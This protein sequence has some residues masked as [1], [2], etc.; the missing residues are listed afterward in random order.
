M[1]RAITASL[2]VTRELYEETIGNGE[3]PETMPYQDALTA[4]Y[5]KFGYKNLTKMI[6]R[7]NEALAK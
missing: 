3:M 6:T 5:E 4:L 7:K 1:N 2:L